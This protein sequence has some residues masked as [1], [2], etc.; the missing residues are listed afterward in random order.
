MVYMLS[1]SRMLAEKE[2]ERESLWERRVEQ[3]SDDGF[4][5]S[6]ETNST[7]SITHHCR[8]PL[9][10]LC[11]FSPLITRFQCVDVCLCGSVCTVLWDLCVLDGMMEG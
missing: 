5:M 11:S 4:D 10:L 9:P 6:E 1:L 2:M 7:F 8:L 3:Q